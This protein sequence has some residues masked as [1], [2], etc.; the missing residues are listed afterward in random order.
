MRDA[1]YK[2]LANS[3]DITALIRDR[4]LKLSI[5][6]AAGEDSDTVTIELD[7]RD[8]AV[9][10]PATGATLDV[11]IGPATALVYKGTYEVDELEEPLEDCT[12]SI[13]GKAAKMKGGIKAPRDATFDNITL[14]GLLDRIAAAH[15]YEPAI[16]AELAGL[17]FAHI[18][19]K[20][21]SDMNLL[22]RLAR[23]H[24]AIAK[25]VA[26]RLVVVPKGQSQTVSGKSIP[27]VPITDPANST[28][29]VTIQERNDYRSVLAY[30]FDEPNQ[31]KVAQVVGEG[32]PRFTIRKTH[33]G[34]EAAQSAATAKLKQL[35]RGKA[36]LSITRPLT[37]SIVPECK[38]YLVNHK[39][40]ANGLWLVEEVDHVI[41]P[42]TVA[43]TAVSCVTP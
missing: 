2:I 3:R 18:D 27:D 21:E 22:T 34:Q 41:E 10:F 6:D 29:R 13:H 30:W 33:Q 37:P 36:T 23:E 39:K 24:G 12:L 40:S 9:Q 20:G 15:G 31:K 14:G 17:S 8:D 43:Y 42:G 26:N 25:P 1:D 4:L 38:L 7:N 5:H 11:Y 32:E 16:S 28:G 35:Q 19:Q